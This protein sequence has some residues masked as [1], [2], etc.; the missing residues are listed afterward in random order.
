MTKSARE[1]Q[2]TTS[3]KSPASVNRVAVALAVVVLLLVGLLAVRQ[4]LGPPTAGSGVAT[5]TSQP[6]IGGPFTLIDQNGNT[7]TDADFRGRYMLVFFGYTYCPDVCPESLARTAAV[8]NMLGDKADKVVP[9]FISVDP[10]RD[11]PEQLRLFA[12]LFHPRLV[13]LTGTPEQ[14]A[15][16]SKAFRVYYAKAKQADATSDAYLIDHSAI[17]YLMGPDGR[18]VAHFSH[19]TSAEDMAK[20]LRE[21]L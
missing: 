11:T 14:V 7:V 18:F 5:T 3:A 16:V 4:Y 2:S 20:R 17:T 15:H 8:L 21:R 1:G 19:Q 13:A 10:E 6:T 9:V 12:S